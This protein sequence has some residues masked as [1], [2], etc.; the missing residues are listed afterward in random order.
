MT[1]KKTKLFKKLLFMAPIGTLP[2]VAA[3]CGKTTQSKQLFNQY[4]NDSANRFW[5]VFGS[6]SYVAHQG[7]YDTSGRAFKDFIDNAK[8][9]ITLLLRTSSYGIGPQ[10][11]DFGNNL[12]FSNWSGGYNNANNKTIIKDN[13]KNSLDSVIFLSFLT[14][15]FYVSDYSATKKA[16]SRIKGTF[17]NLNSNLTVFDYILDLINS[18]KTLSFYDSKIPK[19]V[20]ISFDKNNLLNPFYKYIDNITTNNSLPTSNF[21]KLL[22]SD[23]NQ[24]TFVKPTS[25]AVPV[26]TSAGANMNLTCQINKILIPLTVS[27]GVANNIVNVK[28]ISFGNFFTIQ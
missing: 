23:F 22:T 3:S 10:I 15:N 18:N 12:T 17:S 4:L 5:N 26:P 7:R 25:P 21:S 19:E 11:D 1:F 27:I 2:L 13:I 28:N 20:G 16:I 8:N 24:G 14:I 9:N 6:Y